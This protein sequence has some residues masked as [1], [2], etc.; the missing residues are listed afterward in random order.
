MRQILTQVRFGQGEH[1]EQ[2]P[3]DIGNPA[4]VV[5]D[6]DVGRHVVQRVA[7]AQVLVCDF[8]L[9]RLAGIDLGLQC[10]FLG[11]VLPLHHGAQAL[12][13]VVD[14]RA[15][16]QPECAAT[17]LD[18]GLKRGLQSL[19]HPP[20]V[21]RILVERVDGLTIQIVHPEIRQF[22]L[23]VRLSRHQHLADGIVHV[24][25]TPIIVGN[26]HIGRDIVQRIANPQIV[27]RHRLLANRVAVDVIQHLVDAV[28]QLAH[29]TRGVIHLD[30][31]RQIL[32]RRDRHGLLGDLLHRQIRLHFFRNVGG[33]LHHLHRL[34]FRI[35]DRV[36]GRLDPDLPATFSDARVLAS[37][38]FSPVQLGPKLPVLEGGRL[39]LVHKH[40]VMTT[41][42]FI[43][44]VAHR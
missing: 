18:I 21:I 43:Q 23:D 29:Q 27:S 8:P 36:V 9:A 20:L 4:V 34:A 30:A 19:Q 37:V 24:D 33:V 42:D 13:G 32:G 31:L 40:A 16:N 35:E 2:R 25:H 17:Q 3:V 14:H 38:V 41:L 22:L 11:A 6:H 26:H 15:G 44:G 12:P 5:G 10:Q 7:N 1:V 39:L 28:A